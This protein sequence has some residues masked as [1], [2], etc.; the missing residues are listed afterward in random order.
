MLVRSSVTSLFVHYLNNLDFLSVLVILDIYIIWGCY[1][2][3]WGPYKV[4]SINKKHY[5]LIVVDDHSR[6]VW[7]Y[8]LQLKSKAIIAIKY[9]L[10]MIKTKFDS[11]VNIVRSDNDT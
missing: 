8:L 7:K 11:Y 9:F 3:L 2:D 5:F 4:P 1:M 6:F 10:L